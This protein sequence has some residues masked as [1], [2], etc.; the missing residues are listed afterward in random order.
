VTA[1]LHE[2]V[3]AR[4]RGGVRYTHARQQ[5]IAVLDRAGRPLTAEEVVAAGTDL[6][7]S[8][9]YR[10]LSMFEE[11]GVVRR[12]AGSGEHARYELA[13]SFVGHHHH[14]SCSSCGAMTDIELPARL[15]AQLQKAFDALATSNGFELD[16]HYLDLIG[17]CADCTQARRRV[18]AAEA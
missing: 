10:N 4:L 9:V 13:E 5:L 12:L 2:S 7:L 1:E 11:T 8:S 3:Q 15:E 17:L 6:P 18:G 14:L 16:A